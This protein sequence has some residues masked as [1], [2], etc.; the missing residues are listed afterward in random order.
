MEKQKTEAP[1]RV[2]PRL[3]SNDFEIYYYRIFCYYL[4][5]MLSVD[6][7]LL[8]GGCAVGVGCHNDV[9]A[10]E[11]LVALHAL[12]VDILDARHLFSSADAIYLRWSDVVVVD[13]EL[14]FCHLI[15]IGSIVLGVI[16]NYVGHIAGGFWGDE[17]VGK[18]ELAVLNF[19]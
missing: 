8:G 18:R 2:G 9:Y 5:F 6:D 10:S 19:T 17:I 12:R 3:Q 16:A 13:H 11:S 4:V 1:H 14:V 7:F 15:G